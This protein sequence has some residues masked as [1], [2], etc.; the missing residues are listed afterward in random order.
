M[1]DSIVFSTKDKMTE[2]QAE[3]FKNLACV[4]AYKFN[5]DFKEM[6]YMPIQVSETDFG[7][8]FSYE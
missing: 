4:I 8:R 5:P 3:D 7:I 6:N 2:K 1:I